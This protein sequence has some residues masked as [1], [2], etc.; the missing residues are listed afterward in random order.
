VSKSGAE[1]ETWNIQFPNGTAAQFKWNDEC[2]VQLEELSD[3]TF[4]QVIGALPPVGSGSFAIETPN[5]ETLF[6]INLGYSRYPQLRDTPGRDLLW[7]DLPLANQPVVEVEASLPSVQSPDAARLLL[8]AGLEGGVLT[9]ESLRFDEYDGIDSCTVTFKVAAGSPISTVARECMLAIALL[10]GDGEPRRGPV[11][12]FRS[13]SGGD[14]DVLH[15]TAEDASLEVKQKFYGINDASQRF[16]LALDVASMANLR[17]GGIIIV[18]FATVKDEHDQD[19]IGSTSGLVNLKISTSQVEN[20]INNLVYPAIDGLRVSVFS[21]NDRKV[22]AILIPI[23][24]PKNQPFLVRGMRIDSE[25]V[26]G[27]GFTWVTRRGAAK[28]DMSVEDVQHRLRVTHQEF[29]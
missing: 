9:L 5:A 16:E 15:G 19:V 7:I 1:H 21:R 2:Q 12:V 14:W 26:R 4:E 6:G 25:K 23:Q 17:S 3:L 13:L 18:G 10:Q 27:T 28:G 8:S 20:I 29:G 24:D 11:S 22:L